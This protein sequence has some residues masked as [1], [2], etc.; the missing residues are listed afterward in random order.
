LEAEQKVA[1]AER[2]LDDPAFFVARAAEAPALLQTLEEDRKRV[3]ALYERWE[4]LAGAG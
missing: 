3:A 2:L 1:E 4:Y